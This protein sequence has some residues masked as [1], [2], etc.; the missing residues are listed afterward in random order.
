MDTG[1]FCARFEREI[2][3]NPFFRLAAVRPFNRLAR[4]IL[5]PCRGVMGM[6]SYKKLKLMNLVASLIPEDECYLEVGTFQGKSLVAALKG[7]PRV[8]AVACDN[9]SEFDGSGGN[10]MALE[11]N[12]GRYHL[13]D[14]VQFFDMDFRQLLARWREL[15]LP[16]IGAYFY[17]G[18]HDK[19]SQYDGIK[20]AEP[21][22]ADR[23]LLVVDDWRLAE[24]S[25][26]YAEAGTLQAISESSND[27]RILYVLTARRNGDLDQWW[28]GMGLLG[29]ERKAEA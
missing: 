10:R 2:L 1:Q 5:D 12:L 13:R 21:L 28:N 15:Q 29:F 22:L 4:K 3:H 23:A 16:R 11:R 18:A 7:N 25:G 14:R 6:A 8:K 9:F 26:S 24:D 27:W 19:A 20:Q 17:D